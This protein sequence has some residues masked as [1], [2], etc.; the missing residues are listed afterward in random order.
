M[1]LVATAMGLSPCAI[2]TGDSDLFAEATGLRY[3]EEGTVGEFA[4]W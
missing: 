2:G 4:L 3:E 1:Y